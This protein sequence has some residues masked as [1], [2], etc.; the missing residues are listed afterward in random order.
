MPDVLG[1]TALTILPVEMI[2][3]LE[4]ESTLQTLK[5]THAK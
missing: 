3:N 1:I 5:F 4:A 2:S